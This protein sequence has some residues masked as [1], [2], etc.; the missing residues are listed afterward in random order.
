MQL[1]G[2]QVQLI[3]VGAVSMGEHSVGWKY[4]KRESY[5]GHFLCNCQHPHRAK[6][7]FD[8][9]PCLSLGR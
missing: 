2:G 3:L 5:N 6:E 4:P 1:T 7:G 9:V 8:I